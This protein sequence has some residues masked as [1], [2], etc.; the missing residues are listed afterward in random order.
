MNNNIAIKVEHLSKRYRIGQ[1]V[2]SRGGVIPFLMEQKKSGKVTITDEKM[3]RFWPTL[4]WGVHFVISCIDQMYGGEIFV[5][6]IPS[7]RFMD[8][9]DTIALDAEKGVVG[10]CPEAIKLAP[11]NKELA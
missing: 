9:A 6:R 1:Y 5:P 3:R 4:E 8:L 7:M 10:I 2:G 11:V